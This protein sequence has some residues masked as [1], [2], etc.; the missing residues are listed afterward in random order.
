M[1]YDG[2]T[3]PPLGSKRSS[4]RPRTK[5]IRRL[6]LY[7]VSEDSPILCLN[8]GQAGHNKRTNSAKA[9]DKALPI[10]QSNDTN[11]AEATDELLRLQEE[12]EEDDNAT[13]DE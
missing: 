7:A 11:I 10:K 4:S 13:K 2:E 3:K 6:S 9:K 5:R 1:A 8:C 12:N